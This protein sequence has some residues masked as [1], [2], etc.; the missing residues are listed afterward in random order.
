MTG[1]EM[2]KRRRVWTASVAFK[3]ELAFAIIVALTG[4][5]ILLSILRLDE[6]ARVVDR[7]TGQNLP[8]VTASLSAAADTADVNAAAAELAAVTNERGRQAR[9]ARMQLTIAELRNQVGQLSLISD[10]AMRERLTRHLDALEA[11]AGRLN[12]AM[13]DAVSARARRVAATATVDAAAAAQI[14]ALTEATAEG[15]GDSYVDDTSLP[16]SVLSD[17]HVGVLTTASLIIQ[18][19]VADTPAEMASLR[20]RFESAR[21]RVTHGVDVVAEH[22]GN[23]TARAANLR[24]TT[25]ALLA[26]GT[27]T[28]GLF[29]LRARELQANTAAHERA[30]AM[31]KIGEEL[32]GDVNDL[33]VA[34]E[35][36]ALRASAFAHESVETG[37]LWLLAIAGVSIAVPI[38]I[39]WLFVVRYVS[40]RLSQISRAMLEISSGDLDARMPPVG[41]DEL[42]DMGRALQVFRDNAR[43]IRVAHAEADRAREQAEA[44]SR[45]KSTFLANMSHEL[46]TPLNAIIGYSEILIEE[47]TDRGD[48]ASVSDLDKIKAAGRHLLGLINDILDLSKIEAGRMDIFVERVDLGTL[49]RDVATL[50][51]PLAQKNGNTLN[52]DVPADIG[53]MHTDLTKL[54]QCLVNLLSNASKFTRSGTISLK[55]R[56][57]MLADQARFIFRVADT[58]IGMSAEQ[59]GRLFQ[60]FT[61]ADA[62]TTRNYGGTGLGLTISKHF[63]TMLGGSIDVH[64]EPGK[65]SEFT[66][67]LPDAQAEAVQA[68]PAPKLVPQ[69]FPPGD[70]IKLLV[71]D[72]D[73]SVHHLLSATLEKEGYRLLHAY[74]G[75]QAIELARSTAPDVITLDVMMPRVDGWS[76]LGQLKSAPETARIPVIMISILDERTLGYSLGASEFMTKPIDRARLVALVKQFAGQ[77]G[78]DLVL[79]VD[80]QADVRDIIKTTITGVGLKAAEAANGQAALDWLASHAKPALI[81]LDLM[82]PVMDGFEFLD[83]CQAEGILDNVPVVVLTAR[84]LSESERTFLAQRTMLILTKGAQPIASLGAALS[85]IARRERDVAA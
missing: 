55:V 30:D 41:R 18:A 5:A 84:E 2:P 70:E 27:G 42:G 66:I 74:D 81:L 4:S 82:M 12:G 53:V 75:E 65:G 6:L 85:A 45:T 22:A 83:R 10:T 1:A 32:K 3:L 60:A 37:R 68:A 11:E 64:S 54:K 25:D 39:V 40:R 80:D 69:S 47:A 26:L 77:P 59:Q 29:D 21:A 57:E 73:E 71:V 76:V 56:R 48:D 67:T 36:N 44:A 34:A 52:L 33:V 8:A 61:Q 9:A 50:I 51:A 15:N 13:R 72:D 20:E 79:I 19:A 63:C 7:V 14:R 31:R 62:S 16:A 46:R 28:S 38:L 78:S 24:R 17:L 58:G 49:A 23:D 35:S 43:E